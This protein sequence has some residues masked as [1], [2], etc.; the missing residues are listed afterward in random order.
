M[1]NIIVKQ[2]KFPL[3]NRSGG[4]VVALRAELKHH[5]VFFNVEKVGQIISHHR[6]T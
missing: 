2:I 1:T 3:E 5:H 6:L 4:L